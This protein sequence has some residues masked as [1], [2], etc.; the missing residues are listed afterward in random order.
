MNAAKSANG[1]NR[2][3]DCSKNSPWMEVYQARLER[4]AD[5]EARDAHSTEEQQPTHDALTLMY[6]G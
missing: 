5:D 6:N 2:Y 3:E 1:S 4:R